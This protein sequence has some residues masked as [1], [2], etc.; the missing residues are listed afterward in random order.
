MQ[1]RQHAS[2]HC[3]VKSQ[4]IWCWGPG[5]NVHAATRSGAA[6]RTSQHRSLNICAAYYRSRGAQASHKLPPAPPT[7]ITQL[8][9]QFDAWRSNGMLLVDKPEGWDTLDVIAALQQAGGVK[10]LAHG[11][12]LD[13]SSSGLV[14]VCAG[15]A[16]RTAPLLMQLGK[17]FEGVI[18][19]GAST[20]TYDAQGPL[21]ER[22]DWQYIDGETCINAH[23]HKNFGVLLLELV[24]TTVWLLGAI[25]HV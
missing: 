15:E 9:R 4:H 5:L 8:P 1:P 17:C 2:V 19:L 23:I 25:L 12:R 11:G 6:F 14:L 7:V 3:S 22:M 16:T 10:P 13:V 18:R 21:W 20:R 24:N